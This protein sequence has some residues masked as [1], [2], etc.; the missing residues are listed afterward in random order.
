MLNHIWNLRKKLKAFS[1]VWL[2]H[3]KK[4]LVQLSE[5]ELAEFTE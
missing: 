4:P 1:K 5:P 3:S 2:R